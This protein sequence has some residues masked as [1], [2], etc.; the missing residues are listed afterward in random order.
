[1][2]SWSPLID[3]VFK[4]G[5]CE[6]LL[7]YQDRS[8]EFKGVSAEIPPFKLSFEGFSTEPKVLERA[9]E[10]AK[11]LDNLQY[12]L[13][14]DLSKKSV[15]D[16]L[17]SDVLTRYAK[18]RMSSLL[19]FSSFRVALEAFKEN[20][21]GQKIN[22]ERCLEDIRKFTSN[23]MS[24]DLVAPEG[25]SSRGRDAI[26][27]ALE[28]AKVDEQELDQILL[29]KSAELQKTQREIL[30]RVK[31]VQESFE[32]QITELK[33]SALRFKLVTASTRYHKGDLNCWKDGYFSDADIRNGYDARRP[34]TDDIIKSIEAQEG[35][36]VYG[37]PY[38]GKSILVKRVMFEMADRGYAIIYSSGATA[39]SNPYLIKDLLTS[40]SKVYPKI[41]FVADDAHIA[42]NESFFRIFNE[43]YGMTPKKNIRFLFAAREKQLDERKPVIARALR[44]IP[45]DAQ[46]RIGFTLDDAILFLQQAIKTTYGSEA[47]PTYVMDQGKILY[48]FSQGDPFMFSLSIK[49]TLEER[50]QEP[51]NLVQKLDK[52]ISREMRALI[53][54]IDGIEREERIQNKELWKATIM[55][56]IM[57]IAN[58]TLEP[59]SHSKLYTCSNI[60]PVRFWTLLQNDILLKES[61]EGKLRIRHPIFAYEFLSIFYENYF[62]NNPELFNVHFG[63]IVKCIWESIDANEII[64]MLDQCSSLYGIYR[65]RAISDLITSHYL[66][67]LDQY[68]PPPEIPDSD[69]AKLFCY[70]PGFFYLMRKEYHK[71]LVCYDKA[72]EIKLDYVE[73]WY[74][75]GYV[76]ERLGEYEAAIASYNKALEIDPNVADTWNNKASV[77]SRLG[78]YEEA[79][80]S[81]DKAIELEPNYAGTWYNKGNALGSLGR[82]EEAIKS[83]DKAIELE[84]NYAGT[85]YN[86]GNALGSLGRYEQAIKSYDKAIE[87]E[88]NYAGTWRN[89]G[90][91]L[92]NLAKYEEAIVCFDKVTEINPNDAKAWYNKGLTLLILAKY[93]EAIKSYDKAIELNPN[94]A[95][96]WYDRACS[97]VKKG[98]IKEG[99]ADLKKAF[100]I[101]ENYIKLAKQDKHFESIRNDEK[102]K[103]LVG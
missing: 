37:D 48:E 14:Q 39:E 96:A 84:P 95:G 102:F 11:T 88:P 50:G 89:K 27:S 34:V 72:L 60:P 20:Q 36:F 17:D 15:T 9:T 19:L 29:D 45:I 46:F 4:R 10:A 76:L 83:Y 32:T 73:A 55:S 38:V 13:C 2:T 22:L 47:P 97:E 16:L 21:E 94:D 75:K 54:K 7:K 69:K 85:W 49:Y 87:L 24:E 52:L 3:Y 43:L 30:E 56:A 99:L 1:M 93:E 91:A 44:K 18:A 35:A 59:D 23:L 62:D 31:Q 86:K 57:S 26:S 79:I 33:L 92:Y 80:K 70:G 41:L 66:I 8:L 5:T 51:E 77:L 65:Y 71:S 6:K 81:Y 61:D 98:H 40:L 68:S 101:D 78:K 74:N 82:Y 12:L 90:V 25:L 53:G 42:A 64:V 103:A 67:P 100:E 28:A 63:H 58:I